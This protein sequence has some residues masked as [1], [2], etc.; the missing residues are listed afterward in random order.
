MHTG[1]STQHSKPGRHKEDQGILLI[2][3][4]SLSINDY[5][6]RIL[7]CQKQETRDQVGLTH[8]SIL[9]SSGNELNAMYTTTLQFRHA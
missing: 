3:Y 9:S 6:A 1:H 8:E 4:Y 7:W 5:Y 2:L